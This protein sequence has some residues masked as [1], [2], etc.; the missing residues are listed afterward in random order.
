MLLVT[1]ALTQSADSR[2]VDAGSSCGDD[3]SPADLHKQLVQQL[4]ASC[5]EPH[6]T[7]L[8]K[9]DRSALVN[10]IMQEKLL[11]YSTHLS[12]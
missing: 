12:Q 11:I 10:D 5:K 3:R 2:C 8:T 9:L 7:L 4:G 6:N 1:V